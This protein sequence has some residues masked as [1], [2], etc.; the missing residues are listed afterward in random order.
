M[1][2]VKEIVRFDKLLK[3]ENEKLHKE[4]EELKAEKEA[5]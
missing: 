5:F 4:V 1:A 3:V 2:I